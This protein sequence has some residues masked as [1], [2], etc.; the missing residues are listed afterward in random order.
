MASVSSAEIGA[1]FDSFSGNAGL[2]QINAPALNIDTKPLQ[3]LSYYTMS[4]NKSVWD[5]NVADTN[6]KV[7]QL[8]DLSNISLND[9][10]GK[11]KDYMSKKW[12]DFL[13]YASDFAK[14][15]PKTQE[16]KLQQQ[17]EWQTKYGAFLN[18]FNSGKQRAVAYQAH[19]NTIQN[20]TTNPARRDEQLAELN[21][22]FDSTDIGTPI[23][24]LPQYKMTDITVPN[25]TLQSFDVIG[26][27]GDQNIKTTAK[28]FNPSQNTGN[29]DAAVLGISQEYIPKTIKDASG[30]DIP[31][32]AYE[33]LSAL[34]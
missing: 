34:P 1:N 12:T 21:K 2:G 16:E 7:K 10:R 13:S 19:L 15:Q 27:G 4:Y 3:E 33:N 23:S 31:N 30:I 22:Q 28:I 17:L 20:N 11:D 25:P 29:A 24:A 9:L 26:I 18:D 5:Q 14:K 6:A 8:A 32:P